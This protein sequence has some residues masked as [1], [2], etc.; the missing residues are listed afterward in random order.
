MGENRRWLVRFLSERLFATYSCQVKQAKYGPPCDTT[1][2]WYHAVSQWYTLITRG[3]SVFVQLICFMLWLYAENCL[4]IILCGASNYVV[5]LHIFLMKF[6]SCAW[7]Q[8]EV[9]D[10]LHVVLCGCD[11]SCIFSIRHPIL[12]LLTIFCFNICIIY[13]GCCI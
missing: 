8:I 6:C 2:T 10:C 1:N 9:N 4:D 13:A 5:H 3:M 11:H 12:E 7:R